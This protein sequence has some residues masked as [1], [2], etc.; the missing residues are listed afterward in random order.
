[1]NNFTITGNLTRDP[2]MGV[3]QSGKEYARFTVAC[4]RKYKSPNGEKVTDFIDCSC[5]GKL[6]TEVVA[7]W[8]HKGTKVLVSGEMQSNKGKGDYEK[9]TFWSLQVNEFELIGG[10]ANAK[11][12]TNEDISE[13]L[14]SDLPF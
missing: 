11:P 4:S 12:N 10:N 1:M 8:A 7:K 6:A 13:V 14:D 9:V 2:E 3:T 5:W